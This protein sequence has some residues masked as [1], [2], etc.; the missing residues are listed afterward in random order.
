M[1]ILD[2]LIAIVCSLAGLLMPKN[3]KSRIGDTEMEVERGS[4][5]GPRTHI[6][7]I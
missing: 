2:I 4:G 3:R 7:L 1:S 6:R 5:S